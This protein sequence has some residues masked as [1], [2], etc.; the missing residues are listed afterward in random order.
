MLEI[1][2]LYKNFTN[3]SLGPIDLRIADG[4]HFVLL[5]PSGSGK[6]LLLEIIAGFQN[7]SKGNIFYDG[8]DLSSIPPFKRGIGMVFQKPALFQHMTIAENI[9]YPMTS[10]GKNR[11]FIKQK[12][13]SLADQFHISDLLH[14]KPASLSGGEA[15][16]VSLARTLAMEPKMLL[17]D[18]PLSSLDIQLKGRIRRYIKDLNENGL[19]MLHVTHD[20]EEAIRLASNL[21]I[22]QEG[23]IIQ[24]GSAESIFKKPAT[25][26]V[27]ELTGHKNFFKAKLINIQG[28]NLKEAL[29]NNTRLK[30]YSVSTTENG[31][32]LIDE[33]QI[34]LL[35]SMPQTS[36]QNNLKGTIAR[37][38]KLPTGQEIEI[39]AGIIIFAHITD[40]SAQ[41]MGLHLGMYVIVSFKAS[42]VRFLDL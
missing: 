22:L 1:N 24:S 19:T 42:A 21:G 32:I 12:I 11:I 13:K 31:I 18:E 25:S 34:T 4:E 40:D 5:G 36:A 15:Q 28:Q 27:A 37:I 3:F 39:D 41:K 30:L 2:N 6:S 33:D 8:K 16:R 9:A 20:F 29:I 38:T 14:R 17:L 26:F 35:I 7:P 10:S 23:K